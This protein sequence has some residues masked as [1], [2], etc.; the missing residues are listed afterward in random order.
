M[1]HRS[2]LGLATLLTLSGCGVGEIEGYTP[3]SA[4][5]FAAPF[6]TM[7]QHDSLM[8][9]RE[10]PYLVSI[11]G[12]GALLYYGSRHI[13]D[14]DDPQIADIAARWEAFGPTVAVTENRL[15]WYGGGL[16]RAVSKHGE[17]GAVLHLARRDGVPIYTLEPS[18]EDE[19]AEV[20]RA[21]PVEEATLFYTLRVFLSERSEGRSADDI[22]DLAAHLLRKRGSRPGLEGS[23]P[24]L[25]AL[26]ALW[27][28]RFAHFGPWRDLPPEAIH[29]SPNPTRLQALANVVNEARD[30]H[31]ARIILDFIS[32]GERV[33][34]IAGGSHVVK[35]EP[36]LRAGAE[37]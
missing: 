5:T 18:W 30:R 31:A 6:R 24:D 19:V 35:Q 12:Q 22:D 29:P 27:N 32:Q 10:W 13:N 36:V 2:I 20:T 37:R 1:L 26:D 9:E 16:D 7:A 28:E 21:F 3:S 15:G 33:F 25:T 4:I 14:P 17:F 34:A 8:A 23:L 11:P